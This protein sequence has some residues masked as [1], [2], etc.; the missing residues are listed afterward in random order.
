MRRFDV[1]F[2]LLM[3]VLAFGAGFYFREDWLVRRGPYGEGNVFVFCETSEGSWWLE[4]GNVITNI[5]EDYTRDA[6]SQGGVANVTYISIGNVTA[7]VT[8][9]QL[10][11][12]YDRQ[13][14]SISEWENSGDY[15][16]NVTYTWMFTETQRIDGAGAHW[17]SGGD[18]NLYACANFAGGAVTFNDNDNCTVVWVFTYDCN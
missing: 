18:G 12:E 15:A 17:A 7:G 14:G 4:S 2:V 1:V 6:F 11:S 5:G 3:I 8:K 9:T 13:M 10:D 16:F